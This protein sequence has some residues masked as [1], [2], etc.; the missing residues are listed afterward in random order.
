MTLFY[1]SSHRTNQLVS[2]STKWASG[3][4]PVENLVSIWNRQEELGSVTCGTQED[5]CVS[6]L[7]IVDDA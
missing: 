7:M 1:Y 3:D 4:V 6:I 2:E 5:P